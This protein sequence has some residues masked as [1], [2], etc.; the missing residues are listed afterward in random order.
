MEN[1]PREVSMSKILKCGQVVPGCNFVIHGESDEDVMMKAVEHAR[2]IHDV[3][4][5]SEPLRAQIRAAIKDG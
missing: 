5:L 2:T 1:Q 3:D 4:H